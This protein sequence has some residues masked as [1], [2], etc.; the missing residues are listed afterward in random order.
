MKDEQKM[1]F[2][3]DI[4][5]RTLTPITI[6]LRDQIGSHKSHEEDNWNKQ[7]AECSLRLHKDPQ[8]PIG[9]VTKYS[10]WLFLY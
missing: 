3:I 8:L 4:T 5:S 1:F 6:N 9:S 10:N 2:S 7:R